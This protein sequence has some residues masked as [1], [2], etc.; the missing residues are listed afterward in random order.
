MRTSE[1]DLGLAPSRQRL[2]EP[3]EVLAALLEVRGTGRSSRQA[4]ESRTTSPGPASR[5]AASTAAAIVP[6]RTYG[7]RPR[8]APPRAR[9][10]PRR[11]VDGAHVGRQRA[12]E[13]D[14]VLALRRA[15][16]DQAERRVERRQPAARGERV[17]R[18]R[19]VDAARRR[20]RSRDRL[21]AV[22]HAGE[23]AQRLGDRRVVDA[24]A[25]RP[26]RR[27]P[28]RSRGCA[29]RGCAARPGAGRPPTNSTPSGGRSRAARRRSRRARSKMRQLGGSVRVERAVAV[30]VIRLEVQQH[31][32]LERELVDVLELEGRQLA[33]EPGALVHVEA[34]RLARRGGAA[35]VAGHGRPG[36]RPRG[37]SRRAAPSSSSCPS[38]R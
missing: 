26:P 24:G 12:G 7:R 33:D 25:P 4:G 16:E 23:R 17:R 27:R 3:A 30:E 6:A 37:T 35:D 5:A 8:R 2:H 32:H 14:V 19:V 18:V 28:R 38:C 15:A 29:R 11:E 36:G 21:E 20:R 1:L 22:R 31:R 10:P 9:P 34:E 13:R